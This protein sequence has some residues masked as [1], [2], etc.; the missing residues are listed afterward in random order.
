MVIGSGEYGGVKFQIAEE[1]GRFHSILL[2]DSGEPYS[3]CSGCDTEDDALDQ[4]VIVINANKIILT[5]A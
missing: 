5:D 2:D 3:Y 4:A 1:N